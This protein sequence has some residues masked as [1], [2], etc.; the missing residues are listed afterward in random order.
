MY[1]S[2]AQKFGFIWPAQCFQS[3][4]RVACT[5]QFTTNHSNFL[6]SYTWLIYL[7][8]LLDPQTINVLRKL[9]IM[10]HPKI[11]NHLHWGTQLLSDSFQTLD[12]PDILCT[13]NKY[14]WN[15]DYVPDTCEK[16]SHGFMEL[17]VRLLPSLFLESVLSAHQDNF[18]W[19]RFR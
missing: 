16:T 8:F 14:L 5:L 7:N 18:K 13:F 6:L 10:P 12:P 9:K 11:L 3:V 2:L 15:S 1:H 19:W 17:A 4:W